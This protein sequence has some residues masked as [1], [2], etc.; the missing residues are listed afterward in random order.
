M[1]GF[2]WC[3]VSVGSR[4]LQSGTPLGWHFKVGERLS[5]VLDPSGRDVKVWKCQVLDRIDIDLLGRLAMEGQ[6]WIWID[7]AIL[8]W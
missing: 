8:V 2:R 1:E 4:E 5:L 7:L 6:V 3:K